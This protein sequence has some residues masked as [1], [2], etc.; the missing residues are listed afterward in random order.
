[1][2]EIRFNLRSSQQKTVDSSS[3]HP[4]VMC[5][6][7]LV[8]CFHPR[9][10][11]SGRGH[12]NHQ[13]PSHSPWKIYFPP[14]Q[15]WNPE[16]FQPGR[17]PEFCGWF[18]QGCFPVEFHGVFF[19]LVM[20]RFLNTSP[21]SSGLQPNLVKI[22]EQSRCDSIFLDDLKSDSEWIRNFDLLPL[23]EKR[24]SA[25]FSREEKFTSGAFFTVS[26][27]CPSAKK[28]WCPNMPAIFRA[29]RALPQVFGHLEMSIS[30]STMSLCPFRC[31]VKYITPWTSK[32]IEHGYLQ[33]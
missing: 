25:F 33:G 15:T 29:S 21:E 3:R 1:M 23:L 22:Q 14:R 19:L 30:W 28:N 11:P 20:V 4:G 17:C 13:S 18:C 32:D 5:F 9:A 27:T 16:T 24:M 10:Y 6:C 7:A 8:P 12:P 26:S 31:L 2:F